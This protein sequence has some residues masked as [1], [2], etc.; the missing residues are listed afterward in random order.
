MVRFPPEHVAKRA[1]TE[2]QI[3]RDEAF[4]PDRVRALCDA[5]DLAT[6]L[7]HDVGGPALVNEVIAT[8]IV[9]LAETGQSRRSH[10]GRKSPTRNRH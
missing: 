2:V 3:F 8:H 6:N 7:L 9:R 4:D 10:T 5:Y 1:I